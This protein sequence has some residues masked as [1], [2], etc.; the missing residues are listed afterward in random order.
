MIP[1]PI[2]MTSH[3]F[4][5]RSPAEGIV[6]V[7][8]QLVIAAHPG[9]ATDRWDDAFSG[10]LVAGGKLAADDAGLTPDF[11]PLQL[12]ILRRAGQLGAGAGTA[13]RAIPCLSRTEYEAAA[14]GGIVSGEQ[15]DMV[16]NAAVIAAD[17][18]GFQPSRTARA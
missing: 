14:V 1:A 10:A 13:R 6:R 15:L 16:D 4:T 9:F 12:A 3:C 2:T 7:E 11:S 8:E 5:V 18:R 17:P